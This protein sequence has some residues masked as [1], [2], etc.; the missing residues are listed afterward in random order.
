[1][2]EWGILIQSGLPSQNDVLAILS[3]LATALLCS[4]L[5]AIKAYRLALHEGLNP[6]SI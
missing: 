4:T 6:P 3:I 1:M 5:P 2:K